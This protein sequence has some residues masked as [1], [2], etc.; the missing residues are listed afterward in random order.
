MIPAFWLSSP[1]ENGQSLPKGV[2]RDLVTCEMLGWR[3][4]FGVIVFA[5]SVTSPNP[6]SWSLCLIGSLALILAPNLKGETA[7]FET[8][9]Q[10]FLSE[11]CIRCHGEE[12]QKGDFRIDTL[13]HDFQDGH[14]TE[15]WFEI[16]TRIGAGEM[17]PE[18]EEQPDPDHA[19]QIVEWL[20]TSIKDGKA[21]RMARRAP[22]A[23]YRLSREEYAYTIYDLLGVHYD[24][25]A[26][27]AFTEDPDWHGFER[28]GSELSLSP[29]HVEKY[30]RAADEI[31]DQ[32]F[33]DSEPRQLKTRRDA[34]E[35]DWHNR[36]KREALEELGVAADQVRLLVWPG[37]Q[38]TYFRPD[39]GHRQAAGLYRARLQVSGL[40]PEGSRPPHLTLY[41]KKL[42]R[43]IFEADVLAPED[44]PVVLEFETFIP[45]G[46]VDIS[47]NNAVP[48]PSNS[49]RS[50]RQSGFVFTSLDD[51]KA[52]APWQ[53]KMTDDEG[54][55]L[56]P[57]LIV[58][59]IEWE[60]P[61]TKS[62]DLVKREG[63]FPENTVT[64]AALSAYLERFA[65]RA[66][67]RPVTEQE[68]ARYQTVVESQLTAGANFRT[69]YK[70]GLLGILASKNFTYL[71]EGTPGENRAQLDSWELASRL[72]YFLWSSQPDD[73]LRSA[74]QAGT[75]GDPEVLR[76]HLARMMADGKIERFLDSFPK[77]WLQL[78]KVGMF[79]PDEK[80][81]PDYDGWLETSMIS[82]T[83]E[84]F[85]EVFR[86]NLS[87]G[88]FLDS[89]W[90]ML[91]PRLAGHYGLPIPPEPG[92]QRVSLRSED[93]RG[94]ILTHGAV[95]SL[96][97][98]GTRHR[99]VHRGV[100][101]S[102]AIFGKTPPPPPPN[103]DAIQPN[104]VNEPKAT[105]R[106]KL[107]AHK[108]DPNCASCHAKIDPLGLAFDNYDAIGRWRTEEIV[109]SGLG[110]NP[111]VD[112]SGV[113]PDGRTY[114]NPAEFKQ[115]LAAD[116]DSFAFALTD[117]LATYALRRAMT[118]D[119]RDQIA[120]IAA[121][122]KA[123]GY[124]LQT[125]LEALVRSDLFQK[126]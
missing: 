59:W 106:M 116:I 25:K 14:D 94:G 72:S 49:G 3:F 113:F 87:I 23:H 41:S 96:T 65:E 62:E 111:K 33:P 103:V 68:V 83:T 6:F 105:I 121:Q 118:V 88:Q 104:P 61:I 5:M 108:A 79:P 21:A 112:A 81:Y 30:L 27:G 93:N 46:N 57:F 19:D 119:D 42:D 75:L 71:A 10:P 89:D 122:S 4:F 60:G 64:G 50:G 16:I 43:M 95:L 37:H 9:I 38:L 56:Y 13:S 76:S 107:E 115:L 91:N 29:S 20:A 125:L 11:Y 44:E 110:A 120:E 92:F 55:P 97:S 98:D 28:I 31:L 39:G 70:A 2:P 86:Q 12:K 99:P 90:T 40:A 66:W 35:M 47:I 82:E 100:W 15:L 22:V 67:R 48:G 52:R 51:P 18:D 32:A 63:L 114:Q 8:T 117:K 123:D 77:Q 85:A 17:P 53:R 69:A 24:P 7:S 80:L 26:P 74:S 126:R 124:G 36:N 45:E 78:K 102:E 84:Y 73:E 109:Q 34:L 54:N 58:D 1:P 101:V